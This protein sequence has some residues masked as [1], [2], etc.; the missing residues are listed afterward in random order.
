[1]RYS[2]EVKQFIA[3]N[4]KGTRT[5]EMV[6]LVNDKFKT[7]FTYV[8]MR[9][10]MKNYNLKNELPKALPKGKP[11]KLY[12]QEIKEYIASNY[13]GIGPKEMTNLLNEKFKTKYKASQ[14]AAYYKNNKLNSGVS[15]YFSKGHEPVNKGKKGVGGWKPTQFKKGNVPVNHRPVGS[16]RTRVDG[17]IEVKVA[18]PSTWRLKHRVIWEKHN[19]PIPKEHV[20]LFGDRNKQNLDKDNLILIS[21]NQLARL[22]Q[23]NLIQKNSELTRTG[24]IIA[25]LKI[26]IS[27]RKRSVKS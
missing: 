23:N 7:Q 18:D 20:L 11:S 15:G 24:I 26:K 8:K 5:R 17:Y 27:D 19:G 9:S 14:L 2:E 12:S 21:R 22:N 10:F 13:K 16:E 1:M 3:E 6:K 4:I 25:D